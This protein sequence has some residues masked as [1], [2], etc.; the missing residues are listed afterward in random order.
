ML[1]LMWVIIY[2]LSKN[3]TEEFAEFINISNSHK[4]SKHSFVIVSNKVNPDLVTDEVIVTPTIQ[5]AFDVIEMEEI[6]RDLGF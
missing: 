5:E 2:T 6:E 1:I 4:V 3:T